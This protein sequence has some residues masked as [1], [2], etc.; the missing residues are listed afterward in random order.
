[1]DIVLLAVTEKY[2]R[3]DPNNAFDQA[4]APCNSWRTPA[5]GKPL[6]TERS[7]RRG[8]YFSPKTSAV[9]ASMVASFCHASGGNPAL[10]QVCSRKVVRSQLR[11]TGT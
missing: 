4:G 5:S 6:V 8:C 1:M 7:I 11:S 10:R 9:N 2:R 3:S